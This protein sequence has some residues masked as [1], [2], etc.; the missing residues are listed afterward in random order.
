MRCVSR[1][2]RS[3]FRKQNP[4]KFSTHGYTSS[5]SLPCERRLTG[6]LSSEF[7]GSWTGS[8]STTHHRTFLCPP[9][10]HELL[11]PL[12]SSSVS[13]FTAALNSRVSKCSAVQWTWTPATRVPP[14]PSSARALTK[15]HTSLQSLSSQCHVILLNFHHV[16][17]HRLCTQGDHV[18]LGKPT[19][20]GFILVLASH[21][22][23]SGTF[24]L[25]PQSL[26]S[27]SPSFTRSHRRHLRE[28]TR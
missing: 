3:L 8:P 2:I 22:A 15:T 23:R 9:I 10:S 13:G 14:S 16:F 1:P 20:H 18:L 19:L 25:Q 11:G 17:L 5:T 21:V 6:L 12:S 27:P 7:R 4:S 24:N 26:R 28:L